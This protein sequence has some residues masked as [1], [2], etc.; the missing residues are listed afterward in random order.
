MRVLIVENDP[1]LCAL[2]A[3]HISRLGATVLIT[4]SQGDA[5]EA[6]QRFDVQLILLNLI[7]K[8]GSATAIAD[9]ASYRRPDA[10]V[11]FV[12]N[13]TFFSDG[14]IFQ[15][16]PNACALV[17]QGTPPEDLAMMVEYYGARSRAANNVETRQEKTA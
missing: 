2:W 11:L 4:N 16:I 5:V 12:T 6:L 9:F 13:T 1:E 15:H 17:Q 10:N 3:R 7:L 14:S 8:D